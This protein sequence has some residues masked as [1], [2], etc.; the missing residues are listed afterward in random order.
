MRFKI[1][2]NRIEEYNGIHY[3]YDELGN[4]IHRELS[5]IIWNFFYNTEN[6][7]EKTEKFTKDGN[8]WYKEIWVYAYDPFGR[9]LSKT[10]RFPKHKKCSIRYVWDGNRLLQEYT[11]NAVYTYI[12][13]SSNSFI[14]LV[15]HARYQDDQGVIH[16]KNTL[17]SL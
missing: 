14:P 8:S 6:Q 15:E 7:L 16:E 12:Y 9:R 1:K 10:C 2:G 13:D 11:S 5:D 17:F 3:Y 4:I